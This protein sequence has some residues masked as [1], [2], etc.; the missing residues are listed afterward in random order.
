[1][2]SPRCAHCRAPFPRRTAWQRFC[3]AICRHR[4]FMAKLKADAARARRATR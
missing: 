2:A 1:M 4:S 3:S